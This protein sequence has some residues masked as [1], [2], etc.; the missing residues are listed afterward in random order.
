MNEQ[1]PQPPESRRINVLGVGVNAIDLGSAL[2]V[3]RQ[4]LAR[5]KRGYICV[6]GVHGVM[7]A[8]ADPE[9]KI[10]QNRSLLTTPDGMPLVW[11]GKLRRLPIRRVY[12][13]DLMLA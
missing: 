5:G 10:I 3:V 2:S 8:Q 12:G 7:E 13:P 1:K 6:T 9:F 4:A 11:V